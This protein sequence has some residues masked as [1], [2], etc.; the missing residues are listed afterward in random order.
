VRFAAHHG[1]RPD[2]CEASDPESKGIVESLRH[3][4]LGLSQVFNVDH[5]VVSR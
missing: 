1:F 2:F 3:P 4:E 5:V